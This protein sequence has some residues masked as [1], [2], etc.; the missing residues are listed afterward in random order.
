[1]S[2]YL[3]YC[4]ADQLQALSNILYDCRDVEALAELLAQ[5]NRYFDED[6]DLIDVETDSDD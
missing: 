6:G 1:M 3:L 4:T 5:I 2:E